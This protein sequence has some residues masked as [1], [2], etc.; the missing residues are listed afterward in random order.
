MFS[1]E[2]FL[3][4]RIVLSREVNDMSFSKTYGILINPK[5]EGKLPLQDLSFKD[6]LF[7]LLQRIS[8]SF[9]ISNKIPIMFQSTNKQ[10]ST[11][12]LMIGFLNDD[13]EAIQNI[14]Q[15]LSQCTPISSGRA[16]CFIFIYKINC[17]SRLCIIRMPVTTDAASAKI[18]SGNLDIDIAEDIYVKSEKSYKAVVYEYIDQNK[19]TWEGFVIDKQFSSKE[20]ETASYW[21]KKFLLSD[22]SLTGTAG[23]RQIAIALKT[24]LKETKDN[25]TKIQLASF[26]TFLFNY[27]GK[28]VEIKKLYNAFGLSPQIQ[29]QLK[30]ANP[31]ILN[32]SFEL[33]GDVLEK[34]I[35][36][37]SV[38]LDNGAII[39]AESKSFDK[40]FEIE[41]LEGQRSKFTT[42]GTVNDVKYRARV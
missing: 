40:C 25:L 16:L 26:A 22:L 39:S 10:N 19:F 6:K 42:V 32:T 34:E 9:E 30:Y 7:S 24:A 29:A 35:S 31:A 36:F 8:D 13:A 27:V 38:Y 20:D 37:K 12:N 2:R 17:K 18:V 1:R 41:L 15:T 5:Q 14:F 23:T 21:I 28:I 4:A 33:K 11:R 3:I